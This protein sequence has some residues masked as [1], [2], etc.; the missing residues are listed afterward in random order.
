MRIGMFPITIRYPPVS[1]P[2]TARRGARGIRCFDYCK[3]SR[4]NDLIGLRET[5]IP[6]SARVIPSMIPPHSQVE[7]AADQRVFVSG[8]AHAYKHTGNPYEQEHYANILLRAPEGELRYATLWTQPFWA[9]SRTVELGH[10][11]HFSPIYPR[12]A[13]PPLGRYIRG[14]LFPR[15]AQGIRVRGV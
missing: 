2:G 6:K 12:E 5:N 8:Y 11:R 4:I 15:W 10:G 14:L 1:R 9:E 3:L 7:V 13:A